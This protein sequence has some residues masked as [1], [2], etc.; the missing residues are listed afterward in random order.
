MSNPYKYPPREQWD[1][2]NP[3]IAQKYLF[4]KDKEEA[5]EISRENPHT[6]IACF[7]TVNPRAVAMEVMY[8]GKPIHTFVT[9]EKVIKSHA[10]PYV[11]HTP[12]EKYM[13]PNA[14]SMVEIDKKKNI[15]EKDFKNH[16]FAD[17]LTGQW[18]MEMWGGEKF[19][20][21]LPT[22]EKELEEELNRYGNN[23]GIRALELHRLN[24]KINEFLNRK[25]HQVLQDHFPSALESIVR[26][27]LGTQPDPAMSKKLGVRRS[28]RRSGGKRRSKRS[29]VN[30]KK[31]K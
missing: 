16:S 3:V 28:P 4:V 12:G 22:D 17:P 30:R 6:V 18:Y 15:Y 20:D 14:T 29:P 7:Y 25:Y 11:N 19:P 9:V 24:P 21:D 23:P 13:R 5:R 27:Y 10:F 31:S 26:E 8:E 2:N 1:P